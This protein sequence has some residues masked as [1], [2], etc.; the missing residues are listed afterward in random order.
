MGYKSLQNS[1][2]STHFY[3][4]NSDFPLIELI[5]SG[6]LNYLVSLP[7]YFLLNEKF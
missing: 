7:T 6:C 1:C 5:L 2:I 3:S 4:E